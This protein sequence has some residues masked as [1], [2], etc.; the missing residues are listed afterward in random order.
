MGGETAGELGKL[1][2]KSANIVCTEEE[3]N[4]EIQGGSEGVR[5]ILLPVCPLRS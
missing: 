5:L 1:S 2:G 4:G 3:E